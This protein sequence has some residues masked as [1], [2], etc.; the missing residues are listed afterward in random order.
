M[1]KRQLQIFS[2]LVN[3]SNWITSEKLAEL[4]GVNKKTIQIEIKDLMDEFG[5]NLILEVNR[6][7]GY[8]LLKME[9]Q[10]QEVLVEEMQKHDLES[11]LNFRT[12]T[13]L[14]H[15]LFQEEFVSMQALAETFYL[16]KTAISLEVKTMKR[17]IDRNAGI[18]LVVSGTEGLKIEGPDRKSVV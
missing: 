13:L 14:V 15:L 3:E 2:H 5:E 8:R 9:T 17:W 11:T 7:L 18:T 12:S 4:I 1:E 10:L 6:R 16:S